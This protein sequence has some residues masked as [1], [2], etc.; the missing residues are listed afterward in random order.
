LLRV[1]LHSSL[2]Q[3]VSLVESLLDKLRFILQPDAQERYLAAAG[4]LYSAFCCS[5]CGSNQCTF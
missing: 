5:A 3:L 4:T 1:C 2:L